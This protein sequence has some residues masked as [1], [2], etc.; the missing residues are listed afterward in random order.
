MQYVSLILNL[1][2]LV[3]AVFKLIKEIFVAIDIQKSEKKK[4][5]AQVAVD[6]LKKAETKE[7]QVEALKDIANNF[8]Q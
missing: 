8:K 2:K 4:V 1:F 7:Q 5:E 3:P 6:N